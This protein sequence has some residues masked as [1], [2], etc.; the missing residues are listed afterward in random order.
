MDNICLFLSKQAHENILK[1]NALTDA[2]LDL[3]QVIE[4]ISDSPAERAEFERDAKWLLA[5]ILSD[6]EREGTKWLV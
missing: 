1:S 2:V 4:S 5:E 3:A 6:Q